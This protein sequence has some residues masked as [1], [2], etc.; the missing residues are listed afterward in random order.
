MLNGNEKKYHFFLQINIRTNVKHIFETTD[1]T[2][3]RKPL[4]L[5]NLRELKLPAD[6]PTSVANSLDNEF[7]V[8]HFEA[9]SETS[10]TV[11]SEGGVTRR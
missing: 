7:N 11:E 9:S 3:V 4:P 1:F 2:E 5:T 10:S 6:F 8:R